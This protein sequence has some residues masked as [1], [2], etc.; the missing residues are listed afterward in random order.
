MNRL[1]ERDATRLRSWL[2]EDTLDCPDL[3][4]SSIKRLSIGASDT[5]QYES[6]VDAVVGKY[7]LQ[8]VL[9]R[10]DIAHAPLFP[11]LGETT[12]AP[13]EVS[14]CRESLLQARG[15]LTAR[16]PTI[17][18]QGHGLPKRTESNADVALEIQSILKQVKQSVGSITSAI[19]D[20]GSVLKESEAVISRT[21][22]RTTQQS[23]ALDGLGGRKSQGSALGGLLRR[24]LPGPVA[25]TLC[26]SFDTVVAV[27]SS[28]LWTLVVVGMLISGMV[29]VLWFPKYY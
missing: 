21:V 12:I 8:G 14:V 19:S 24:I 6:L 3:V 22:D 20:E 7:H 17:P 27:V 18:P 26:S 23:S 4:L 28:A 9:S 1:L 25:Y 29:V 11:I 16:C 2:L 13:L 10:K 15:T 5:T